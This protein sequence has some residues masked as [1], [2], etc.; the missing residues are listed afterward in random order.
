MSEFLRVI[1]SNL[2]FKMATREAIRYLVDVAPTN[3]SLR[4][5]LYEHKH[6]WVETWLIVN[7]HEIV[8]D[9]AQQLIQVLVPGAT[10]IV[11][12]KGVR[13]GVKMP[14]KLEEADVRVLHDLF[15][16]LLSLLPAARRNTKGDQSLTTNKA[17]ED[18]PLGY[19]KLTQYFDLLK[20]CLRGPSEKLIV[21]FPPSPAHDTTRHTCANDWWSTVCGGLRRFCQCVHS[22]GQGA[23]GV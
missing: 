8:R 5:W 13:I 14:D 3:P 10:H 15:R 7:P 9:A 12:Q 20:W 22:T 11:D 18:Y 4:T 6:S 17:P 1:M 2:K 16:H 23:D 21:R 19:W